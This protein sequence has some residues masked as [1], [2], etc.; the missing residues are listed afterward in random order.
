MKSSARL[1]RAAT[2][3]LRAPAPVKALIDRAA[4][5]VGKTRSEFMLDSARRSAEDV[6]LDRRL[7]TLDAKRYAAFAKL[8]DHPPKPS[9]ELRKL[10]ST[11]A[12][13]EA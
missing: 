9:A 10:L 12:P 3:N 2:I 11:K 6:L 4:H 7:F 5:I 13:W 1:R 8:L